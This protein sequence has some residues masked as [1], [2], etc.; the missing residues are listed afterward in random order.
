MNQFEAAEFKPEKNIP[1]H[2]RECDCELRVEY[3]ELLFCDVRGEGARFVLEDW[4]ISKDK[5]CIAKPSVKLQLQ[6]ENI[7][8]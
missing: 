4:K 6:N 5:N 2:V 8:R 7:R 3:S 1:R